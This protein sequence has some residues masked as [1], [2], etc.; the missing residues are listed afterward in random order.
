MWSLIYGAL[1]LFW[2]LGSSG[3]PFGEN[4]PGAKDGLS[5]FAELGAKTGG[6]AIA[7]LGLLGALGGVMMAAPARGAVTRAA[8]RSFAWSVCVALVLVVPDVRLLQNVAYA[9]LLRFD[10][11]DWPVVNQ[12]LC[13]AG[14]LLWGVT[15][16]LYGRWTGGG[17]IV[18]GRIDAGGG[19]STPAAAA[20]WGRW[21]TM[22][23]VVAPLPY[24]IVRL[25]WFLGIPLGVSEA[26]VV[27]LNRDVA[28]KGAG[29][30][31]YVFGS[32]TIVGAILTLGLIQR[33]GEIFPRWV[34]FL[35][36]RRVPIW[37]AVVPASL[38]AIAVTIAGRGILTTVILDGN[39]DQSN[40]G[41]VGPALLW[42]IWGIALGLATLAY[43]YRRRGRCAHCGRG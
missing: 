21:A 9:V 16:V 25:A 18:C 35:A 27:D 22:V 24:G 6:T 14:G 11:L 7:A 15:A 31:K 13:V 30:R 32:E 12:F 10:R 40:W 17:C 4:D 41:L 28:A 5:L 34:P 20:R 29:L 2:A 1:G 33:W 3:F 38:V 19:W 39:F 26:F 36:G 42:P 43:Y 37:S 23:A 8:L